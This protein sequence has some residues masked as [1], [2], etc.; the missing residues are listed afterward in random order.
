MN[1][2]IKRIE[3]MKPFFEKISNNSYLRAIRDG[4]ISL[5]PV[6]LFFIGS[7]CSQRIQFS[8]GRRNRVHSN[9]SV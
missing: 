3:K 4:F 9:E 6:I 1:A 2:M 5:I 8:L 7:I